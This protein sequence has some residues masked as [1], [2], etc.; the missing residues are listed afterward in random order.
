MKKV[1]ALFFCAVVAFSA[2]TTLSACSVTE[3]PMAEILGTYQLKSRFVANQEDEITVPQIVGYGYSLLEYLVLTKDSAYYIMSDSDTTPSCFKLDVTYTYSI[4]GK[5]I[6]GIKL[7]SGYGY[8][9]DLKIG[10]NI[11]P[12]LSFENNVFVYPPDNSHIATKGRFVKVDNDTTF[13]FVNNIFKLDE[14][15]GFEPVDGMYQKL[16]RTYEFFD[17]NYKKST[18]LCKYIRF[19]AYASTA[20][21]YFVT[22]DYKK[23]TETVNIKLGQVQE[24]SSFSVTIDQIRDSLFDEETGPTTYAP[25]TTYVFTRV[26][27][28]EKYSSSANPMLTG[29]IAL[30]LSRTMSDTLDERIETFKGLDSGDNN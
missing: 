17:V 27:T 18:V 12:Y 24:D 15:D 14:A 13:T 29:S 23:H 25:E 22:P 1:I 5:N 6:N 21:V 28:F 26:N 3:L 16:N 10:K 19:D 20:T 8:A 2:G 11:V 9:Y 4:N 30:E 7:A